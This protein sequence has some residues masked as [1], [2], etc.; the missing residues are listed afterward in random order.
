MFHTTK[1]ALA[2]KQEVKKACS[3]MVAV[4]Q[5]MPALEEAIKSTRASA[6]SK[7]PAFGK[8]IKPAVDQELMKFKQIIQKGVAK[9]THEEAFPEPD[10]N[11][12]D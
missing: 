7:R 1:L 6:S 12:T 5:M 11:K 3:S 2:I 10:S 8:T 9:R 4:E